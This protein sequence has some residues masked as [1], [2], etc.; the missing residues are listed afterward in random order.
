M[1]QKQNTQEKL[2][3]VRGY[4][5]ISKGDTPQQTGKNTFTIPSQHGNGSYIIT[6]GTRPTCTCPDFVSRQKL[7]KHIHAV[8]FYLDFNNKVKTENKGIVNRRDYDLSVQKLLQF[9]KTAQ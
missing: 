1:Q 6:I 3:E 7:C 8:R 5:I 2:R 4:A 9:Y